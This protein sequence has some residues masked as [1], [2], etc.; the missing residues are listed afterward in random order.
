MKNKIRW[1]PLI[2]SHEL[3]SEMIISSPIGPFAMG[4]DSSPIAQLS[5]EVMNTNFRIMKSMIHVLNNT[6]GIESILCLS[7]YT[8]ILSIGKLF[9]KD[10]V[11]QLT[12]LRLIG[13]IVNS[14]KIE[15]VPESIRSRMTSK[16]GNLAFPNGEVLTLDADSYDDNKETFEKCAELVGGIYY[17]NN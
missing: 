7:P 2:R 15:D 6:A 4:D 11:R 5:F 1:T 8:T 3:P 17:E 10:R 12:E 13:R 9:C 14:P 16:F